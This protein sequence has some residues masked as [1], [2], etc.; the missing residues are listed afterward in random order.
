[1]TGEPL[2]EFDAHGDG[3][4]V[5]HDYDPV[6][7]AVVG[8]TIEPGVSAAQ[9]IRLPAGGRVGVIAVKLRRI[10]RPGSIEVRLGSRLGGD[11]L[12]AGVIEPA[13]V[14]PWFE[15]WC[16]V[17]LDEPV[18]ADGDVYLQLSLPSDGPG[19]GPGDDGVS[20]GYEWYG[21][22]SEDVP[23]AEFRPRFQYAP[24]FGP[25]VRR[26]DGFENP[27][28]IDYGTSTSGYDGGHAYDSDGATIPGLSFAFAVDDPGRD[29]AGEPAPPGEETPD[30]AAGAGAGSEE[31][32]FAFV[33]EITGPL[34]SGSLRDPARSP[35]SDEI[36][37]DDTWSLVVGA[38]DDA[39]DGVATR[40]AARQLADF[41]RTAM[42]VT[43]RDA[44]GRRTIEVSVAAGAEAP[45]GA[46]PVD[47]AD[48]TGT[49]S[50]TTAGAV[51]A[52]AVAADAA[53]TGR[54]TG[55]AVGVAEG[56]R[57][58]VTPSSV[59]VVGSDD[60]GVMRG[61]HHLE[62]EMKR[63]RGPYLSLGT[64]RRTPRFSPR[65]TCAPFYAKQELTASVGPYTE[66]MLGRIARAGFNA[67]W[68]WGDL[69][70]VAHSAV[71]PELDQG[72][73]ARQR[74]LT[75]LIGHA[76]PYGIDVYL[77]LANRPLPDEFFRRHLNARGSMFQAYG[78]SHVVCTSVPEVREHLR[79]ATAD[80]GRAVPGLAGVVCIV[81]GEG[82]MHCYTRAVSCPR[83]LAR[84]P[85]ETVAELVTVVADGLRSTNPAAAVAVW[86][87]SATNTWSAD[88]PTQERLMAA[89]PTSVTWLTE[90]AKEGAVTFGG[91]TIP[92][93]D[94]PVSIAGPSD[95]FVRQEA[96]A[97]ELGLELWVKTEHA[98][99]LEF[100][101]T[102]YIPALQQWAGRYRGIAEHTAV[103]GE[104]ANW[105]HYGF[106][107]GPATELFHRTMWREAGNMGEPHEVSGFEAIVDD[108][109]GAV[110][111]DAAA[112][113][114]AAAWGL[115][116]EA[117]REY[118]F[119][120]RVVSGP[121]Q[122]GPA[123]PL[124]FNPAYRPLHGAPRQFANDL[125]WTEPWGP[126][127]VVSQLERMEAPWSAGVAALEQAVRAVRP[128]D[129]SSRDEVRRELGVAASLLACIRS[130]IHVARFYLLR[131]RLPA[132]DVDGARRILAELTGIAEREIE[133]ART[134][135]RYVRADS[136][137]GYANSG[138][139][140]QVGVPRAG[141]YSPGSIEKKI[142]Q[143][144][145]VLTDE[146]PAYRRA[147]PPVIINDLTTHRGTNH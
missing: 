34:W 146:I 107:P 78:G 133:N 42:G 116:S 4:S 100:I 60:R 19:D 36:T 58:E 88:D 108:L 35:A 48:D 126:E 144:T 103:T 22:G 8:W 2:V 131:D 30:A 119:S 43:L 127:L 67:I 65:I 29:D 76:R 92:A 81:G 120:D 95:R 24:T 134:A 130:A 73:A 132:A 64:V 54:A 94:Y 141:I 124:F 68:V 7:D 113:H 87:Y 115:F 90:F 57:V 20:S 47:G 112:R 25:D 86:P 123:H 138:A 122:K 53:T 49:A 142:D 139:N 31:E 6:S 102:P 55:G 17:A 143:V 59:A 9:S 97:R 62:A 118:P 33:S 89:L 26:P 5:R 10:G 96:R 39:A 51:R 23:R 56:F 37:I 98:V 79:S 105:M 28:N 66:G 46:G 45:G 80:L 11:D 40:T 70:E 72:V 117:I 93:Y 41:L 69:D 104:F 106:M 137:I 140:D 61:L 91:R 38:G 110:F 27:A 121:I 15:Q 136:R 18:V 109:A 1:M 125:S 32:R 85:H 75:E 50:G 82:L 101:Q 99:A 77:Y 44:P 12:A 63:R 71:Y 114:V 135:L 16:R 145:R 83:C 21:T 74:A 52:G 129:S 13:A 111:G 14:N 84:P 147:L 128:S 3:V